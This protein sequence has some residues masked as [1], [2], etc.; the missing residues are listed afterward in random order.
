L[1]TPGPNI[2][3]DFAAVIE[4]A[5]ESILITTTDLDAP[6]PSIVYVNPAFERM[7]GWSRTEVLGKSPR[8]LQARVPIFESSLF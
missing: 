5:A 8:M 1:P 2:D 4:T 3:L 6:G 7:T